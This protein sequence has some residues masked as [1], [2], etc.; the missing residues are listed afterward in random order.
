MVTQIKTDQKDGYQALQVGFNRIDAKKVNRPLK[1]HLKNVIVDD[2]V[3]RHLKEMRVKSNQDLKV[4]DTIKI[5]DV[6]KPGDLIQVSGTSKGRGFSGVMKRWGFHGGP[7]T[8]G[9]SDRERAPGSIGQGTDPGRVHKG[10]KMPGRYGNQRFTIRNLTVLHIDPDQN[11]LLISGP[12]PGAVGS[13][14]TLKKTGSTTAPKLTGQW[15]TP[16]PQKTETTKTQEPEAATLK[17]QLES[18]ANENKESRK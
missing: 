11:Q 6:V 18:P 9:Q 12:I 16:P 5:T 1:A 4:G 13:L 15:A 7:R 3:P 14:I 10:K 8:H 17:I 2:Q